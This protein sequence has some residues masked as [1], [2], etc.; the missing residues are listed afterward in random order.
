MRDSRPT[1]GPASPIALFTYN[2]LEHTTRTV[3]ALAGNELAAESD[4]Y[5][6][7]DGPR[8][9]SD[10]PKIKAI[11]SYLR[12]ISGFKSVII[13]CRHQNSGLAHSIICGVTE[14]CCRHG[15]V[16]VMEDDLVTA[17][18]FLRYMNEAL[19]LYQ[20]ETEVISIHGYVYPVRE[21]LPET[22]F[23]RGADCWGW[24]TW[25][26]GW[27]LFEPNGTQ[28]LS[29][30][31]ARGL[32]R[33]FDFNHSFGFTAMLR[34]QIAEKN[35]SWAI[36]WC[37]SAFL[38]NKLTLYPGRPLVRNIGNDATGVHCREATSYDIELAH[39]PIA[40]SKPIL[41]EN[42]QARGAFER[43]F[44][45]LSESRRSRLWRHMTN[46]LRFKPLK[47]KPGRLVGLIQ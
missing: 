25:S 43:Y 28:L 46:F 30:L 39:E 20:N 1:R 9:A 26:R 44:Q 35:D 17:P 16:I 3:E 47:Q 38:Q 24:A 36:R 33:E 31:E 41:T 19:D 45:C 4:L 8:S 40:M 12:G 5:V 11:R 7:S 15:R 18:Y 10:A 32:T 34:D 21:P 27:A 37:A 42:R 2:R 13:K 29:E 23:L 14:M 6:F 22:F